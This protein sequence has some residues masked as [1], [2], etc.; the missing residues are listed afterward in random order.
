MIFYIQCICT[1][2]YTYVCT[3]NAQHMCTRTCSP[4][5]LAKT[6]KSS[7]EKCCSPLATKHHVRLTLISPMDLRKTRPADEVLQQ[8]PTEVGKD[9][10]NKTISFTTADKRLGS[11]SKTN[12]ATET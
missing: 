6:S 9:P 1:L 3:L 7:F 4:T 2:A 12:E 5:A 10:T 11:R 8:M